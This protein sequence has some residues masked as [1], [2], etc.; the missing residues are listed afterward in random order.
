M[1]CGISKKEVLDIFEELDRDVGWQTEAKYHVWFA[2]ALNLLIHNTSPE[3]R[4][5]F[6]GVMIQ[7]YN[8]NADHTIV[9]AVFS[10]AY[11][12][13]VNGALRLHSDNEDRLM[14]GINDEDE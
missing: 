1:S 11:L 3:N 12:A 9:R 14:E 8:T 10:E 5:S 13:Y 4:C 6:A 7:L 2:K